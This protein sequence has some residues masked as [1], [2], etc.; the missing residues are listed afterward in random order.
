MFLMD[1]TPQQQKEFAAAMQ[2]KMM[3]CPRC[4]ST[5]LD[6]DDYDGDGVLSCQ[7]TCDGC[8]LQWDELYRYTE[9]VNFREK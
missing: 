7:V 8:K 9:S 3:Q 1:I 5:D 6:A 4:G 2:A